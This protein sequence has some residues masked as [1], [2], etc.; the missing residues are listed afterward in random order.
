MH[1]TSSYHHIQQMTEEYKPV[2]SVSGNHSWLHYD[3][4][5]TQFFSEDRKR[6]LNFA[7][8]CKKTIGF[9]QPHFLAVSVASMWPKLNANKQVFLKVHWGASSLVTLASP[10]FHTEYLFGYIP[11]FL[12]INSQLHCDSNCQY[13]PYS[14]NVTYD[15]HTQ[16]ECNWG[17]QNMHGCRKTNL[18]QHIYF[19]LNIYTYIN[20]IVTA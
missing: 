2:Y 1:S 18:F 12:P 19:Q 3:V 9:F 6:D 7:S 15:A 17:L 14:L 5:D 10:F 20:I 16:K 4:L 13:P 8:Q 11:A